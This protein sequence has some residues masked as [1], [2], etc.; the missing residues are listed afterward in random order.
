MDIPQSTKV[1][2]AYC[3][4]FFETLEDFELHRVRCGPTMEAQRYRDSQNLAKFLD[5]TV[6]I[7]ELD[8]DFHIEE[9]FFERI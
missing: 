9:H 5:H 1:V 8:Y 6:P 4:Y 2:C 3:N 7:E